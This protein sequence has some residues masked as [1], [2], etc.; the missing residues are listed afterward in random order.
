[1]ENGDED[2]KEE[3]RTYSH[4]QVDEE[5]RVRVHTCTGCSGAVFIAPEGCC[6]EI[7]CETL[8]C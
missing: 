6:T 2:G 5:Y 7:T 1:V 4:T 3:R 8:V